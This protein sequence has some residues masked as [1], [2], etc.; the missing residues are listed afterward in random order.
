M[1]F[2]SSVPTSE[3]NLFIPE[4]LCIS[5]CTT[6][7]VKPFKILLTIILSSPPMGGDENFP[8]FEPPA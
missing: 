6:I 2:L 4:V 3:T 7:K 1:S 8:S 5:F